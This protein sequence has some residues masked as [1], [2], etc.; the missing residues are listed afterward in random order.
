MSASQITKAITTTEVRR[1]GEGK[2]PGVAGVV[3][4]FNVRSPS[5]V[6]SLWGKTTHGITGAYKRAT[7]WDMYCMN[8]VA[9]CGGVAEGARSGSDGY[10]LVA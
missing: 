3:G 1:S 9:E 8:V 7:P 2:R 6:L 4:V 5:G 10:A